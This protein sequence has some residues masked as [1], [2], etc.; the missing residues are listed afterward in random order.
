MG[1]NVPNIAENDQASKEKELEVERE[2]ERKKK[3]DDELSSIVNLM[4]PGQVP[5]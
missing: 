1:K 4:L 5:K 3:K 2:R